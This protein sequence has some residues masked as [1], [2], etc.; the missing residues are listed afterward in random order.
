MNIYL[1]VIDAEDSGHYGWYYPRK[2]DYIRKVV[3][4]DPGSQLL[5]LCGFSLKLLSGVDALLPL[6]TNCGLEG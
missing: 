1:F 5:V 6:M 4:C 3:E 2:I